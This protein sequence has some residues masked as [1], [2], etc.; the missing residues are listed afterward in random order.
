MSWQWEDCFA[1]HYRV[2]S[3]LAPPDSGSIIHV[4]KLAGPKATAGSCPEGP[5][6]GMTSYRHSGTVALLTLL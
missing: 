3:G 5:A 6:T 1:S 2:S 4:G